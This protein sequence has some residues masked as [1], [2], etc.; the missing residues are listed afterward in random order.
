M[1]TYI[2]VDGTWQAVSGDTS[3]ICGY[4]KVDG[5]WKTA[6]NTYVKVS[7]SW[8]PVCEPLATPT[9]TPSVGGGGGG[10]P[11]Q[12]SSVSSLSPSSGAAAGG[13][14]VTLNGSFPSDLTNISVAGTNVGSFSRVSSTAYS[15]TMPAGTQ[16]TTAQIQAFNGR[17][18]LMSE[19][20]FTYNST[21]GGGSTC[22]NGNYCNSIVYSDGTAVS[23][24][25]ENGTFN[26][27]LQT[28]PCGT[29]GTRTK[30]YT[31][32]TPGSCPNISVAAGT[33][34]EVVVNPCTN[35]YGTGGSLPGYH[36]C[37][38]ADVASPYSCSP[39]TSTTQC[40][41]GGASGASCSPPVTCT[42]SSSTSPGS[43]SVSTGTCPSGTMLT[44]TTT[45]SGCPSCP[46]SSTVD[47]G[48]YVAPAP[49]TCGSWTTY[50]TGSVS[51]CNGTKLGSQP[52][53]YQ[54]QTCSDGSINYRTTLG[55]CTGG[56]NDASCG[57]V[58][59]CQCGAYTT[60]YGSNLC[61]PVGCCS[62]TN[63]CCSLNHPSCTSSPTPT[64]GGGGGCI[65]GSTLVSTPLGY[66]K[67]EDIKV[68]DPV[69][70]VRFAELSSDETSYSLTTWASLTMTPVEMLETTIKSIVVEKKVEA[71]ISLNGDLFSAEHKILVEWEG[72]Y[73]FAEAGNI[74]IGA[75]V[76]T[77]TSNSLNGLKWV[78][79]TS[80]EV[81]FEEATVYLF[82]TEEEDVLFTKG[83]LTHNLKAI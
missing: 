27:S 68:G 32:V 37:T 24:G 15:F 81:V 75:K 6:T 11:A 54:Y 14:T 1:A 22:T 72:K 38:Q 70:S 69:H 9:P 33:C 45:Y 18:P 34:N 35:Q 10:S 65:V 4:V 80:N 63:C 30:A 78:M 77:R 82:D 52:E 3:S 28:E 19:L 48:C 64:V 21:S 31:C 17:T 42:C 56:S 7:G 57:Y 55:S 2:K 83:M 76:L 61:D 12:D 20:T 16:G 39:C 23:I 13:Y 43:R 46:S 25:A 67:A 73:F 58:A 59:G 8:K 66:V 53:Y 5:A 62:G 79:I 49:V 74:E 26:G 50:A 71:Y 44:S 36:Q 41:D 60:C 40:L 51:C 29:N 47:T